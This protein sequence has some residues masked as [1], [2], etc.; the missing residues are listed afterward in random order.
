MPPARSMIAMRPGLQTVLILI[1]ALLWR[2]VSSAY[3][4]PMPSG[5][6]DA[7][8]GTPHVQHEH[9]AA[10]QRADLEPCCDEHDQRA[11]HD[12][13]HQASHTTQ[14]EH[15]SSICKIACDLGAAPALMPPPVALPSLPPAA[16][17][18][19]ALQFSVGRILPPDHP[20]PRR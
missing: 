7:V 19:V 6:M 5:V 16:F 17:D 8:H 11:A 4:L 9:A 2:G 12:V 13:N 15:G 1:A 3:A 10:V 14:G 18:A 20:P